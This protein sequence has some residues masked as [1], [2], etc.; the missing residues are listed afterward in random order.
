MG[1]A[2]SGFASSGTKTVINIAAF[3]ALMVALHHKAYSKTE[4]HELTGLTN[5]TI[6]RWIRVLHT[7]KD[8]LVYIERYQLLGKAGWHTA[9][10]RAGHNMPDA[11]K[12]KAKTS[13]EYSRKRRRRLL[14]EASTKIRQTPTGLIHTT[15]IV[16]QPE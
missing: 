4:L 7:G 2:S 9:F 10:W 15:R 1:Y 6:S 14:L 11:I 8:R 13:T 16:K 12:P 3:K 5:T